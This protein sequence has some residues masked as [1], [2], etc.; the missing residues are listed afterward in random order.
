MTQTPP[1]DSSLARPPLDVE[2]TYDGLTYRMSEDVAVSLE[3]AMDDFYGS[4]AADPDID[5]QPPTPSGVYFCGCSTCCTRETLVITC[6]ILLRAARDGMVEV[7][8]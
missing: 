6:A 1:V 7:V 3:R 5:D 8:R 2:Y 4:D